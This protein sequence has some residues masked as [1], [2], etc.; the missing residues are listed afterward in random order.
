VNYEEAADKIISMGLSN[1]VSVLRKIIPNLRNYPEVWNEIPALA[2]P[3]ITVNN[4]MGWIE[5]INSV[6]TKIPREDKYVIVMQMKQI[7][8]ELEDHYVH[9][10]IVGD[11]DID[12]GKLLEQFNRC[13]FNGI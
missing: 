10:V 1:V 8:D 3:F 12:T 4:V 5:K 11:V 9:S 2:R 13:F 7:I 6:I